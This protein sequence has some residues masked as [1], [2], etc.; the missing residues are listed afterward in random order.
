[1]N[2]YS[3]RK[4]KRL[5]L[6][7]GSNVLSDDNGVRRAF[8]TDIARQIAFLQEQGVEVVLVS[9]GAIALAM[10]AFKKTKKPAQ[11]AEKQAFAAYG[12]PLLMQ[13]YAR[14]LAKHK[15]A[16][17]QILL[18][19]SDLQHRHRFLNA[20]ESINHLL[21]MKILPIVNENDTV[22]VE[23]IQFGDN[24]CLSAFVAH[25]VQADGLVIFSHVDGLYTANPALNP[26]ATLIDVVHAVN[27]KLRAL[28][29]AG[30]SAKSSGGMASKIEACRFATE[31]GIPAIVTS[32]FQKQ[33]LVKFWQTEE[34]RGTF[35]MPQ[36]DGLSSRQRWIGKVLKPQGEIVIDGGAVTA[37]RQSK[38]SLLASGV[39]DV[40]GEFEAGECVKIV[41]MQNEVVGQGLILFPSS[42]LRRIRGLSSDVIPSVLGRSVSAEV[43]GKDDLV[44]QG[45]EQKN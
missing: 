19:H 1:M 36:K 41:S 33:S 7:V 17:A 15:V 10:A 21:K 16:A 28:V 45:H 27:D 42:D 31:L 39:R 23:E 3:F 20:R 34:L 38:K 6:K 40:R 44:L 13:S 24:D 22:S 29:Y 2:T 5:V 11:I 43:M 32:G 4:T 9:S 25:L 30:A 26:D 37:L 12:Q 8:F 35:F 18:T 14:A